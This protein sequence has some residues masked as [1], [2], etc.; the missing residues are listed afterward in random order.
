MIV[1]LRSARWAV[2]AV[3]L[4]WLSSA[5]IAAEP[6]PTAGFKYYA[7]QSSLLH[8]LSDFSSTFGIATATPR[9]MVMMPPATADIS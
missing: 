7:R 5:C 8:V 1:S 6:W 3:A 9:L 2:C 4:A